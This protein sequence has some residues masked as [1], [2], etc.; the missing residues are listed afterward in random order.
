MRLKWNR[1]Q[2]KDGFACF[3]PHTLNLKEIGLA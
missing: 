3:K 1:K 2:E